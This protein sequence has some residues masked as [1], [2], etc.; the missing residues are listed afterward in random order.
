MVIDLVEMKISLIQEKLVNLIAQCKQINRE[1]RGF[2]H[3]TCKLI[4]RLGATAQ[5]MLPTKVQVRYKQRAQIQ[6]WKVFK[7]YWA[8]LQL[9]ME[10]NEEIFRWTQHSWLF[11][12]KSLILPP[13]GL[14]ITADVA[15]KGW[16]ATS[17]G[18]ST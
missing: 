1:Q 14:N 16:S 4:G 9:A 3:G 12:E 11:N 5:A 2:H 8:W 10:A 17:H 7:C 13:P 15:T 6:A 18:T